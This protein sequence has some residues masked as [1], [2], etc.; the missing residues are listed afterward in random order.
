[1]PSDA[2]FCA[3]A[4]VAMEATVATTALPNAN[5]RRVSGIAGLLEFVANLAVHGARRAG[6]HLASEPI[7][8][9]VV[10]LARQVLD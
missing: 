10:F 8:R 2:E 7:V 3:D 4:L 5:C 9:R 6:R 1:M